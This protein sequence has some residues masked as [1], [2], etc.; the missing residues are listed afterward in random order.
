MK[1]YFLLFGAFLAILLFTGCGKQK[2]TADNPEVNTNTGSKV[3]TASEEDYSADDTETIDKQNRTVIMLGRSVMG[4]WFEYWGADGGV[5]QKGRFTLKYREMDSPPDI[6]DSVE[7][8][9][10]ELSEEERDIVFFKFCFE[11]FAGEDGAS[12]NL[13]QNK[14]YIEDVYQIVVEKY[15]ARLIIGN[16]LP[17]VMNDTDIYLVWNHQNYNGWLKDFWEQHPE[18]VTVFN[19]YKQLASDMGAL[20]KDYAADEYDSHLNKKGYAALDKPFWEMM[21][22]LY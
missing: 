9:M 22:S 19:M 3:N 14:K 1:K 20:K 13:E 12:A 8:I 7:R 15:E 16:A 18:N 5:Q 21:E 2:T 11:D 17:Q 6:V 10:A 4:G